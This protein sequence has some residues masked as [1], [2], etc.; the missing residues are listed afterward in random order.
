MTKLIEKKCQACE[1][2]E[3][4]LSKDEQRHFFSE[5]SEEWVI[6]SNKLKREYKFKNFKQGLDFTNKLGALAENEGHHPD[7]TLIWGKVLVVIYTH[8]VNDLTENDFIL[9]AKCDLILT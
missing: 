9:A 6:E 8:K 1:G 2:E 4:A 5:L 7:I 3:H